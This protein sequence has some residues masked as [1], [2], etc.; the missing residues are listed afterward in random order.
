M[1]HQ[2]YYVA[3]KGNNVSG[4]N[5]HADREFSKA[6]DRV[7]ERYGNNLSAFYRDAT[8]SITVEKSAEL[9]PKRGGKSD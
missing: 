5:Q 6:L 8:R 3:E 4:T 9:K 1:N 7:Y 2:L